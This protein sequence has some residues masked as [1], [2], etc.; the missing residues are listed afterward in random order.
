VTDGNVKNLLYE[1]NVIVLKPEDGC[2]LARGIWGFNGVNN[3]N[4]V[5]RRNTVK[6]EAMPG[7]LKISVDPETITQQHYP[8]YNDDVNNSITAVTFSERAENLDGPIADPVIFEDNRLIGNVNLVVI[9]EGY[10]ICNSVWMYRTKMEKIEHD[11]DLFRPVRLGFWY[12]D[13]YNNRLVDTDWT[14]ISEKE[15]SPIFFGGTGKMEIRYGN[16]KTLT[17]KDSQGNP[18]ANKS[19]KLNT[20]DDD[21]TQTLHTD[22]S[23]K[24]T[25]DLLTVRY[26]KYGNSEEHNQVYGIPTQTNYQQYTFSVEGYNPLTVSLAQVKSSE[27]LTVK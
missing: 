12:W 9:G 24:L 6:V 15:K 1:N 25:F 27:S 10:G 4:I 13:T 11:S 14:N 7:N 18:L 2:T 22:G 5:Y 17:L 23:G 26:F 19:I 16:S 3:K 21:Y 20:P 8:Y